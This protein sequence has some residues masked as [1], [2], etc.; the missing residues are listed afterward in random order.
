[1]FVGGVLAGFGQGAL[2]VEAGAMYMK[3]PSVAGIQQDAD[4]SSHSVLLNGEYVGLPVW[5]KYNYIEKPLSTFFVKGGAVT[6]FLVNQ[7][8][9]LITL[10]TGGVQKVNLASNDVMALVGIGGTTPL[11]ERLAFVLDLSAFYGLQEAVSGARNQGFLLNIGL[12]Y[13]L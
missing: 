1:M 12:S 6:A 5:V 11:N 7:Q 10:P 2:S 13:D 3:M 4:D 9:E 8:S